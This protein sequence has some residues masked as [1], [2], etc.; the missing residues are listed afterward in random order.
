MVKGAQTWGGTKVPK[1]LGSVRLTRG[2]LFLAGMYTL[3][4]VYARIIV[5]WHLDPSMLRRRRRQVSSVY[6]G[7]GRGSAKRGRRSRKD[8][9]I[10]HHARL[11]RLDSGSGMYSIRGIRGLFVSTNTGSCG[12]RYGPRTGVSEGVRRTV[13]ME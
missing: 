12:K 10:R 6:L 11:R 13:R 8:V 2:I 1:H 9:N 5:G 7:G 3:G 4:N